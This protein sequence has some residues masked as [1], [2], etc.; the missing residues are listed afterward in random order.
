[1]SAKKRRTFR[2]RR[3]MVKAPETFGYKAVWPTDMEVYPDFTR[4]TQIEVGQG[5]DRIIL[6]PP[7]I[8][9]LYQLW[10]EVSAVEAAPNTK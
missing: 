9:Y 1:M 8:E 7:A 10:Q 5:A 6:D 3:M 2:R 4:I